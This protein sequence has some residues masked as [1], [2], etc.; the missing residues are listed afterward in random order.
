MSC[1]RLE[2]RWWE[3]GHRPIGYRE[4]TDTRPVKF[5]WQT[6]CIMA[7]YHLEEA[8]QLHPC[9]GP[10]NKGTLKRFSQG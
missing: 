9:A 3:T 10:E 1:P 5:H 2:N 8:V 4:R 6:V 7:A